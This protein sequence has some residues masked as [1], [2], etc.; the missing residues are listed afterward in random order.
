MDA[1]S[2]SRAASR[3]RSI[4]GQVPICFTGDL[5][6]KGPTPHMV[7][8]S[9]LERRDAGQQVTLV[10]GNHDQRMLL[11]IVQ[12]ESGV[13]PDHLPR[14]ERLCWQPCTSGGSCAAPASC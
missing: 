14:T 6:T 2:S 13:A 1:A 8:R 5:F 9:I 11:A 10:C 4:E 7:V 12:V 3:H